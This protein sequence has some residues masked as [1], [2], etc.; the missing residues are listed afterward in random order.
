MYGK[1]GPMTHAILRLGAGLLFLQ[2]GLQKMFGLLGGFGTPGETAQLMSRFGV[3]GILETFGGLLLIVGLA[4]R[5]IALVLMLEMLVAFSI[6]HLPRGGAPIQN[7][8]EPALL[9]AVIF[10]FLAANGAGPFS[11]DARAPM[12]RFVRE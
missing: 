6:A 3:A 1:L 9:Y 4:T 11:V 8:G 7:G 2:H 5:P 10:A 12:G